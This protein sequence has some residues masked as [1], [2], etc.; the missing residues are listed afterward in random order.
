MKSGP[1]VGLVP[2]GLT[3]DKGP[4]MRGVLAVP[5]ATGYTGRLVAAEL[6]RRDRPY[7]LGARD[8]R[9]LA[10]VPHVPHGEAF[11]VDVTD[12]SGLDKFLDG[13]DVLVNTVGPFSALGLPVVEAAV[14][15]R[16]GSSEFGV[17]RGVM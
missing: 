15:K 10:E 13:A 2:R 8:P 1:I 3:G 9:R 4:T 12:P 17:G 5:G 11:V 6:A 7:R 14:R 16:E